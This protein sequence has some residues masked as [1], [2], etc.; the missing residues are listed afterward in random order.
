MQCLRIVSENAETSEQTRN[1]RIPIAVIKI[2]SRLLP[3]VAIRLIDDRIDERTAREIL[4]AIPQIVDEVAAL[5]PSGEHGPGLIAEYEEVRGEWP[6]IEHRVAAIRDD[7]NRMLAER[8]KPQDQTKESFSAS[9]W[10][11]HTRIYIE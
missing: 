8:G 4:I 3:P 1:V 11:E 9:T 7:M 6:E 2:L 10:I 5:P